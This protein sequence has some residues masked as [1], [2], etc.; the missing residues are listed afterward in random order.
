[1]LQGMA[2]RDPFEFILAEL[3]VAAHSAAMANMAKAHDAGLGSPCGLGH[4]AT[5]KS[6]SSQ[7]LHLMTGL[8]KHRGKGTQ[9]VI[10]KHVN[11]AAAT[12]RGDRR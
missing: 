8:D 6:M 3:M 12:Q 4:L 7:Y 1:M 9:K 2:P 10:V 5:F 11:V